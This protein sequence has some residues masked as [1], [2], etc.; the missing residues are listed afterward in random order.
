MASRGAGTANTVTLTFAN[1]TTGLWLACGAAVLGLFIAMVTVA[2]SCSALVITVSAQQDM[3]GRYAQ[4]LVWTQEEARMW[5]AYAQT[6]HLQ[7][8]RPIPG[9]EAGASGTTDDNEASP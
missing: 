3:Q 1:G 7:P 5:R 9:A 6:G 2:L 4:L 8:M